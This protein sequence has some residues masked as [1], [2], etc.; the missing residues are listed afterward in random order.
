MTAKSV[1]IRKA[2]SDDISTVSDIIRESYRDVAD[3]FGLTPENCPK[4]PSNCTDAWITRDRGRGV[5][6]YMLERGGTPIGCAALE[7]ADA[8]L[9]YLERLAVRPEHRRSGFGTA[10]SRHVLAQAAASGAVR[11]SIGI[12]AAQTELKR[13][14][15]QMGFSEGETRTFDHLP[16]QVTFMMCSLG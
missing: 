1:I 2:R 3:R 15:R 12:I 4:H 8:D 9:C 10:L 14:Y 7:K 6:F 16:F 5:V 11:V 13:W